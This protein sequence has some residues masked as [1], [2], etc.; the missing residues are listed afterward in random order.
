MALAR[1]SAPSKF[2]GFR[3]LGEV[4]DQLKRVPRRLTTKLDSPHFEGGEQP[5]CDVHIGIPGRSKA[6][7]PSICDFACVSLHRSAEPV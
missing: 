3:C 4:V 2:L 1:F 6:L 5:A 7:A